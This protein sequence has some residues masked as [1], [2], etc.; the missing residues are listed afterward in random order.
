M[1]CHHRQQK[2][3][4]NI[5]SEGAINNFFPGKINL[6]SSSMER[7]GGNNFSLPTLSSTTR[8]KTFFR[9]EDG[10]GGDNFSREEK[11]IYFF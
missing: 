11:I 10:E 6:S 4:K 8:G 2:T 1:N 9:H 7:G 3:V 5:F